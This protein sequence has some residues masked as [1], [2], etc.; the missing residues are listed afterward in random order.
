MTPNPMVYNHVDPYSTASVYQ[1]LGEVPKHAVMDFPLGLH[2]ESS[3]AETHTSQ[4]H[5]GRR[6]H[7]KIH[8]KFIHTLFIL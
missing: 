6:P 2:E 5:E 4:E 1:A 8:D 7:L 3:R